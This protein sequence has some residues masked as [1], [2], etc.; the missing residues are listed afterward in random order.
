MGLNATV[1]RLDGMHHVAEYATWA[2]GSTPGIP[3]TAQRRTVTG[4]SSPTT[5]RRR[6]R[7]VDIWSVFKLSL[8]FFFVC[9][10][11]WLVAVL[12]VW[13]VINA[14]GW[15]SQLE[16][17]TG[18]LVGGSF[19]LDSGTLLRAALIIDLVAVVGFTIGATL[20]AVLYNLIS[21]VVGGVTVTADEVVDRRDRKL[22]T[23][24]SLPLGKGRKEPA[25]DGIGSSRPPAAAAATPKAAPAVQ[26]TRPPSG[27]GA[28]TVKR[29]PQPAR[30]G[31]GAPGSDGAARA[32]PKPAP[33]KASQKETESIAPVPPKKPPAKAKAEGKG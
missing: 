18:K 26:P 11:V 17:F 3:A 6:V 28:V 8:L 19:R 15:V 21:D 29:A 1:P 20:L 22:L 16:S 23:G 30:S 14:F 13:N 12:I 7:H 2:L 24:L 33:S 27:V 4:P 32:T 5:T 25:V 9:G 10:I 31:R